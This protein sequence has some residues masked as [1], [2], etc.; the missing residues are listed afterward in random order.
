MAN[1]EEAKRLCD[2]LSSFETSL[3]NPVLVVQAESE[4]FL[5]SFETSQLTN[6]DLGTTGS[7]SLLS[8]LF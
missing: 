1:E 6:G 5:S 3:V 2:F 4:V 7:L 8:I